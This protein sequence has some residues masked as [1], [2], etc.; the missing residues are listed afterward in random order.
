M[1]GYMTAT[2]AKEQGFTHHG[3]YFGIPVWVGQPG[4]GMM[5]AT[6][7]VP[8]WHLMTVFHH[9]EAFLRSVF[10]PDEEPTFQFLVGAEI[11]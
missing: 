9:V 7:W 11:E 6:K 2:Q 1:H 3:K 5:V 10:W 8:M 4:E